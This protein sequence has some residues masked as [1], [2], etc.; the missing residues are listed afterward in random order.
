MGETV[1][2][3]DDIHGDCIG[4][5]CGTGGGPGTGTSVSLDL[6]FPLPFPSSLLPLFC[7]VLGDRLRRGDRTH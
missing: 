2:G 5:S 6:P 7:L 1:V 3:I 4:A